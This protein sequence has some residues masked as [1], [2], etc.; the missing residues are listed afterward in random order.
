M[1]RDERMDPEDR[2]E[3]LSEAQCLSLL[4]SVP[5]G[6]VVYVEHALPAVLPVAFEVAS[7][8]RLVLALRARS[9]G[10]GVTRAL[11][12]TVAAFQADELDPATR[13]GWSVLVH[14]RAEVVR[15]PDLHERLLRTGPRPWVSDR[16]QLF[17]L[18]TPELVTG[19]RLLPTRLPNARTAQA[20]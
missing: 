3:T 15:D 17:V 19:R 10:S 11:D 20:P 18:I 13:T 8:G 12:G 6:R 16:E 4:G 14:G 5:V 2:V 1:D 7:D 9:D